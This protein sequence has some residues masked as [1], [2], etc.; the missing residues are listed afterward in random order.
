VDH[1]SSLINPYADRL[2]PVSVGHRG[3]DA[4]MDDHPAYRFCWYVAHKDQ[5]GWDRSTS[6]VAMNRAMSNTIY[7]PVEVAADDLEEL[8]ALYALAAQRPAVSGINHTMPHKG[9]A[10]LRD[11]VE[12][13][14]P[15]CDVALR[16]GPGHFLAEDFNGPGFIAWY[17]DTVGPPHSTVVIVGVG[18]AG[19]AIARWMA[20]RHES[21]LWLVDIR[22]RSRL[23]I[24]LSAQTPSRY[25]S[26]ISAA[27]VSPDEPL[28]V[29]NCTG[30]SL[31]PLRGYLTAHAEGTERVF[32]DIRMGVVDLVTE[33]S[34]QGWETHTGVGM[35]S[36]SNYM[37]V[38]ALT[39]IAH[40][41]TPSFEDFQ[42]REA[43]AEQ[44]ATGL[45]AAGV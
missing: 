22:D 27:A 8:R 42:A 13:P 18:G 1:V 40:E 34:D 10:A 14:G 32:V 38:S 9:N 29:I 24:E 30:L 44:R 12:Q 15:S 37:L 25:S 19:E 26:D 21:C 2:V 4:F 6:R 17:E 35:A 39:T 23:S 7:A 36:R 45:L 20:R 16:P 5:A 41:E 11:F 3:I 28:T 31:E 33:A 43:E